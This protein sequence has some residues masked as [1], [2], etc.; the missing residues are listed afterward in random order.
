M[1]K[2][3]RSKH[4]QIF[5]GYVLRK[6]AKAIG[7]AWGHES[8]EDAL[9]LLQHFGK[10]LRIYRCLPSKSIRPGNAFQHIVHVNLPDLLLHF[11]RQKR[12]NLP[13][14]INRPFSQH[15]LRN[16]LRIRKHPILSIP[17]NTANRRALKPRNIPPIRGIRL[18]QRPYCIR[19]NSAAFSGLVQ[20]F[21]QRLFH[22]IEVVVGHSRCQR[23]FPRFK[24][25]IP[26]PSS[27]ILHF[28]N[29]G[30]ITRNK[31]IHTMI[32]PKFCR[33]PFRCLLRISLS[34]AL[35]KPSHNRWKRHPFRHFILN[36]PSHRHNSIF[37]RHN[38]F[39]PSHSINSVIPSAICFRH[40]LSDLH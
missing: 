12:H 14:L 40:L 22:S 6:T 27:R 34:H 33:S 15:P 9:I 21:R 36:K 3:F 11:R 29:G 39:I 7:Q 13:R 4:L 16:H 32:S 26:N 25:I 10:Q 30:S 35:R 8:V 5:G 24:C 17:H 18:L 2:V 1:C 23:A 28:L 31:F 20:C 19:R 38:L 37:E